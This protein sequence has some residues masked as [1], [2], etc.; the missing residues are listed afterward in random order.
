MPGLIGVRNLTTKDTK[1]HKGSKGIFV[2]PTF[3]MAR[4]FVSA[5]NAESAGGAEKSGKRVRLFC[6][7]KIIAGR[8]DAGPHTEVFGRCKPF[9]DQTR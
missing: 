7:T 3:S 6:G 8:G 5:E 1:A 2:N 9:L 4:Y